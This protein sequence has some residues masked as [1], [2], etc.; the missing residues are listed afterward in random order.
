MNARHRVAN[1]LVLALL[2]QVLFVGE[3][4]AYLEPGSMNFVL[5]LIVGSIV[6]ALITLKLYWRSIVTRFRNRFS[7]SKKEEDRA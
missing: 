5:Q 1:T 2:V 7:S 6:G 4:Q 3:A